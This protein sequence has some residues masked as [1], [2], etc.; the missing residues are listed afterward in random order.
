[1]W[2]TQKIKSYFINEKVPGD[3]R[4]CVPLVAEGPEIL[5]IVGYRQSKRY[6]VTKETKRILE[7][8]FDNYGG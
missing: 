3:Q 8:S 7:I 6:Q 4:G 5:W 2:H 1:M